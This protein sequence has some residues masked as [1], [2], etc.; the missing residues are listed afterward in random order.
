MTDVRLHEDFPYA[1]KTDLLD[2]ADSEDGRGRLDAPDATVSLDNPYC[3]DRI[4][5]DVTMDGDKVAAIGHVVRGCILCEAASAVISRNGLGQT[6]QQLEAA[7]NDLAAVLDGHPT[8]KS[9]WSEIPAFAAVHG[10]KNRY[11]CATLPF[12]AL[13]AAVQKAEQ[14][15]D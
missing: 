10:H 9:A 7:G 6:A 1:G 5:L 8:S 4:T 3:G 14:K 13:I 2:L 11:D 15:E 12:D